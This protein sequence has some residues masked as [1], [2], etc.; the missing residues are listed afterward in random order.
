MRGACRRSRPVAGVTLIELVVT[1]ALSTIVLVAAWSW[2]WRVCAVQRH[3]R[4]RAEAL[5]TL[6]FARR[7]IDREM[8]GA[9][10]LSTDGVVPCDSASFAL[11]LPVGSTTRTIGYAYDRRRGVL[12]RG[13]AASYVAEGVTAFAVEYRDGEGRPVLPPAGGVLDARSAGRVV[14]LHVRCSVD[15]AGVSVT[16]DWCVALRSRLP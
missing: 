6:A 14:A 11:T 8:R 12:W 9:W 5:S 2:C 1:L 7:T 13:A 15:C 10:G 16:D 4:A 3:E